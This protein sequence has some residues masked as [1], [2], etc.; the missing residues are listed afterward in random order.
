MSPSEAPRGPQQPRPAA[1]LVLVRQG[2]AGLEVLMLLRPEQGDQ[3]SG[4]W[5]FPGGRV[6]RC[7]P[8][9]QRCVAGLGDPAASAVLGL[10]GGGIDF[11]IAAIR[12]CFEEAGV[13]FAAD[14]AGQMPPPDGLAFLRER[15][16]RGD[17]DLASLCDEQ[18]LSLATDRLH[19]VAH[20]VTPAGMPK[21]FDTRFFLALLPAGQQASHDG[22]ETLEHRWF[23]PAELLSSAGTH[24]LLAAT[25]AVLK[26]LAGFDRVEDLLRWA[27][28]PREVKTIERRRSRNAQGPVVL[29]PDHPAWAEVGLLDPLGE[30][31]ACCELQPGAL[32][33]LSARVQ[34]LTHAGGNGYLVGDEVH[35]WALI[36]P[37][38][39]ADL[40]PVLEATAGRLPRMLATGNTDSARSDI[41]I[42]PECL[43]RP[44]GGG[45]LLQQERLLFAGGQDPGGLGPVDADWAAPSHGFLFPLR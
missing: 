15:L 38:P 14:A 28:S 27:E 32:V 19:Y 11:Y 39:P 40:A 26:L 42:G 2:L 44:V 18:R 16:R 45:W 1:T 35:G 43:L 41:P 6:D 24:K 12:E 20:W 36:D 9:C 30:G 34:R 5:V 3:N 8:A 7:D 4:A 33:R 25:Q 13:L 31:H 17:I 22:I 37:P 23:A 10:P 21:R 29:M